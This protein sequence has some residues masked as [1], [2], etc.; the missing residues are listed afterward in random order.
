LTWTARDAIAAA[1][2]CAVLA[3]GGA[4]AEEVPPP[5][6][7][8]PAE[9]GGAPPP[10][11]PPSPDPDA[12]AADD[13]PPVPAPPD[14]PPA[15]PPAPGPDPGA[16]K[17][18]DEKDPAKPE[19]PKKEEAK[20]EPEAE[21]AKEP[22]K[23]PPPAPPPET[24]PVCMPNEPLCVRGSVAARFRARTSGDGD[25]FDLYEYLTLRV[26]DDDHPG[27]SGSLHARLAE[28]L[29]GEGDDGSFFVFDSVDD[30]YDSAVTGRLYHAYANYRPCSGPV[31]EVRIGRQY[32]DAGDGF[33]VDGVRATSAPLDARR[34]VRVHAF[35]GLPAH[36]YEGSVEGDF[37]VGAGVTGRPWRGADARVDWVHVEDE[38]EFYGKPVNDVFTAELRQRFS[39]CFSVRGWYQQ[40][41][42][43]PRTL[44][45]SF[46]AYLWRSDWTVRGSAR[47]QLGREHALVFDVDPYFAVV[48][49][50]EP[51]WD[52]HLAASKGIGECFSAEA[53]VTLRRLWD[54]DDEGTFNREFERLHATLSTWRWPARSLSLAVTGEWWWSHDEATSIGF[55][56]EWKP[57]RCLKVV[58]GTDYALYRTDLY[59]NSERLDSRGWYLR[60][61]Y[62]T[63]ER[64]KADLSVRI[65][66]D[67]FDTYATIQGGVRFEFGGG[68]R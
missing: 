19:E 61:S 36:L 62:G 45:G 9:S 28:D 8:P 22:E 54:E 63:S 20:P 33:L 60:A 44:A 25:D 46:L 31:E 7:V 24:V 2:L 50:L 67:D 65:E 4:A 29:D 43:D 18:P 66:D 64:W 68:G 21:K 11:P 55:E 16:P 37:I 5:S 47:S 52:A 6:P 27:W 15:P 30:T 51:Y 57:S 35:V 39:S 34:Q 59:T 12:P 38:N 14:A 26:R 3:A 48:Q 58:L 40:V 56:A 42:D 23:A 13:A 1:V 17:A 53:G 49:T 10:P 41:D 32:V